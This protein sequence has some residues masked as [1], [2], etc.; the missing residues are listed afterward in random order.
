MKTIT[1]TAIFLF[2]LRANAF[3]QIPIQLSLPD[4]PTPITILSAK[5]LRSLIEGDNDFRLTNQ[6][7]R[8]RLVLKFDTTTQGDATVFNSSLEIRPPGSLWG[9]SLR[10]GAFAVSGGEISE[11]ILARAGTIAS[12]YRELLINDRMVA[13]MYYV[14]RNT[15]S[16]DFDALAVSLNRALREFGVSE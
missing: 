6:T 3:S 9:I 2:A 10:V 4:R 12:I 16:D 14:Q 15:R 7:D 13:K 1:A 8:L 11:A 5:L